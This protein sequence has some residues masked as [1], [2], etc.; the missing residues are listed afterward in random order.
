VQKVPILTGF[1][2]DEG[3][4]FVKPYMNS[5]D[6]FNE[7]FTTLIPSFNSTNLQILNELYP[8]PSTNPQSP[9]L[10]TRPLG[11]G[12]QFKRAS[13]TYGHY[14]YVCS[15]AAEFASEEVAVWVWHGATNVSRVLSAA[16]TSYTPYESYGCDI[17]S[18][19]DTQQ[20]LAEDAAAYMTSFITTGDPN[21]VRGKLGRNRPKWGKYNSVEGGALMVLGEGNDERAG[22]TSKGVVTV[23]GTNN[24]F[25]KE[26]EFWNSRA[27]K[28]VR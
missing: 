12:S 21:A 6:A 16:H 25:T 19:S 10:D 1:A 7:L 13:T 27:N 28:L 24:R 22:G 20:E 3:T 26:C 8:D 4:Q 17:R 15:A 18:I 2:S 9:Y 5:S 11:L 23:M 14:A